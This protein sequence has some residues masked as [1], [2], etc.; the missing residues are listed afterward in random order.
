MSLDCGEE[1]GIPG[2]NPLRHKENIQF[3]NCTQKSPNQ[4]LNNN[5]AFCKT[6]LTTL[7][8][9]HSKEAAANRRINKLIICIKKYR[10][11]G[12]SASKCTVWG[13]KKISIAAT[14]ADYLVE[15]NPAG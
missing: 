9:C 4:G 8:P 3:N 1:A 15:K 12:V 11:A 2:G 6:V 7:P 10:T 14:K 13:E 5:P